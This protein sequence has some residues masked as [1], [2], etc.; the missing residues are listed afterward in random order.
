MHM[1]VALTAPHSTDF[2][3]DGV[4]VVVIAEM[5]FQELVHNFPILVYVCQLIGQ[6]KLDFP[7]SPVPRAFIAVSRRKKLLGAVL[8]PLGHLVALIDAPATL[9][10]GFFTVD[11]LHMCGGRNEVHVLLGALE[12]FLRYLLGYPSSFPAH[13]PSHMAI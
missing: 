8:C 2:V 13:I 9:S 1:R 10:E 11:V 4:G 3:M 12:N 7:V 5:S 6:G